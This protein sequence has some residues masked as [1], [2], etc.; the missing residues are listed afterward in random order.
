MSRRTISLTDDLYDYL[1]EVSLREP[2]VLRRL[3]EETAQLENAH[4][5]ISPEQGQLMRL[6]VEIMDAKKVLELGTYTGYSTL[7][8]AAGVPVDGRVLTCDID[9]EWPSFGRRYWS[10][11]GVSHKI[12]TRHGQA[13]DLL[14]EL[15]HEGL[16]GTFDFVFIDADKTGL[17]VYY[18]RS[19]ELVRIGGLIAVDNTLW[20]GRVID[21]E[22]Y[23]NATQAV[24]GFNAKVCDDPRVDISLVPIGDGMTLIRKRDRLLEQE[25]GGGLR[26]EFR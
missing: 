9:D 15:L 6:I 8:L 23:D 25:I 7:C 21:K 16:A 5:Q 14:T 1:L 12:E 2:D 24:R 3:R 13:N 20:S 22:V 10:E 11:A 4:M 19:L 17:D 26:P 18:E